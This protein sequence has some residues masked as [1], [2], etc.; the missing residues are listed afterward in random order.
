MPRGKKRPVAEIIRLLRDVQIEVGAG[1]TTPEVCRDHGISVNSYYKW[2]NRYAGMTT[3]EA[4][5]AAEL[6]R[7]NA[8]LKKLVAEQALDA[9]ILREALK[10]K[11]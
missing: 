6:R 7:E 1:R 10:G 5:E 11:W 9:A 8:R 2:R 4:L 3:T